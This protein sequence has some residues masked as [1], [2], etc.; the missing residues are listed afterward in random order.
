MIQEIT[1]GVICLETMIS[2]TTVGGIIN[3]IGEK[4]DINQSDIAGGEI[5]NDFERLIECD[6]IP[7]K[8]DNTQLICKNINEV[9]ED[10]NID[11]IIEPEDLFNPTR[12]DAK[13][14]VEAYISELDK[15]KDDKNY[16]IDPDDLDDL[17]FLLNEYDLMDK[18]IKAYEL[19]G[20]IYFNSRNYEKEY[21]YML[22]A[23]ELRTRYPNRKLNYRVMIKLGSNYIDRGKYEDA[24]A[25]YQKALLNVDYIPRKYLSYLYYNYAL[26]YYRLNLCSIAL[27]IISDTLKYVERKDY[28]LWRK[29]YVL[30]GVCYFGIGDYESALGSYNNALQVLTFTGYSDVKY[31]I[32]G[33]MAEVYIKLNDEN[34]ACK[35]LEGILKD[36]KKIDKSSNNYSV[37]SNQ[38]AVSY[39]SLGELEKAEKYYKK[40]L[41]YAKRNNQKNYILKSLTSLINLSTKI[42]IK[43]ILNIIEQYSDDIVPDIKVNDNL[44]IIL[45]CLKTYV[46]NKEYGKFAKLIDSIIKY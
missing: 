6:E 46:D 30:E 15:H 7:V 21:E 29:T 37:I 39:E 20:D 8:I 32:Y 34:R 1:Y 36:I 18:K 5:D 26:A 11:L 28:D 19:I 14:K 27:E 2:W 4:L 25:L 13:E 45:K 23:W 41:E 10:K 40:S 16:V 17:E 43:D 42:E 24:I 12:Y 9:F 33:N 31:L 3:R 22:K 38:L 44:L 35:Y